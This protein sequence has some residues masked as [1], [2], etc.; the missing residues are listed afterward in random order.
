MKIT[1]K[2]YKWKGSLQKR[3]K[4]NY[5]VLHHMAGSGSVDDIH[6]IHLGNGWTGIGYHF[7]VRKDG[8][9]FRGRPIDAVGAHTSGYNSQALGICFEG[10]Y[11]TEKAMPEVQKKAGQELVS[12]LKGVYPNAKIKK[13]RDFNATAC[14][15]KNFPFEDIASGKTELTESSEIVAELGGRGIM[16]NVA[17]WNV[18]CVSDANAYA[19]AKAIANKTKN[20][21]ERKEKLESVNDIV[22][23]LAHRGIITD[24]ALW[25]KLLEKDKDLYWLGY[26]C[27]NMTK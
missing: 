18:K 7:Y 5:I 10:N 24:K 12:Y 2:S 11:E 20:A 14:P 15:G 25:L 23:E 1:E 3:A 19:L 13:H 22:W 26:K 27:V 9:V 4:T 8:T 6:R 21:P 17:L 16:T